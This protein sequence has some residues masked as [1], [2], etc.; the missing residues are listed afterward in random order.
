M[1]EPQ[2]IELT[3]ETWVWSV[4]ASTDRSFRSRAEAAAYLL[5][6]LFIQQCLLLVTML[7]QRNRSAPILRRVVVAL[8][9]IIIELAIDH[10]SA[11]RGRQAELPASR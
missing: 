6:L 5:F 8:A 11:A 4:R 2:R 10:L 7:V 1:R 3:D 9:T